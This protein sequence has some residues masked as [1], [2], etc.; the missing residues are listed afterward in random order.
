M[1][2]YNYTI[3]ALLYF[4]G[5]FCCPTY[6]ESTLN[7][8]TSLTSNIN[9]NLANK[10]EKIDYKNIV[11]LGK[12]W[13]FLKY[14]HPL[15]ASGKYDWDAELIKFLPV[16]LSDDSSN[17]KDEILFDWVVGFGS[18]CEKSFYRKKD[19]NLAGI[20]GLSTLKTSKPLTELLECIYSKNIDIK[21]YYVE[22]TPGIGNPS[23]KREKGYPEM[24]LPNERYRLLSLFRYWNI[25]HYFSPYKS[26]LKDN[27]DNV[28]N[29]HIE[30]FVLANNE[31][32]YQHAILGLISEIEDSHT[33]L[34]GNTKALQQWIGEYYP[35]IRVKFI[36]DKLVVVSFY[37]SVPNLSIKVGDVIKA[38][39]GIKISQLVDEMKPYYTDSNLVSTLKAIATDILR[40]DS[41]SIVIEYSHQ[42]EN[43][44]VSLPLIFKKDLDIAKWYLGDLTEPGYKILENG[45]GYVS[46]K[47]ITKI[48]VNKIK[49]ELVN[50][51]GLIIDLRYYPSTVV[52]YSLGQFFTNADNDFVKYKVFDV[53]NPGAFNLTKTFV[54]KKTIP[55]Y[56]GKI[57]LLV[58]EG[59]KSRGEFTTMA[60]QANANTIVVG[61]Q[62]AGASGNVSRLILPGGIKTMFTSIG[63][64]YP[65]GKAVQKVGVKLNFVVKPTIEGISKNQD[66]LFEFAQ[67]LILAK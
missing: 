30:N 24:A 2:I 18:P 52:A 35:P 10:I 48:D 14:Y 49:K 60:F 36:E 9:Y 45:I 64:Y 67:A 23:F 6:A 26:L 41:N 37:E 8:K 43:N 51:K 11:L 13:G 61:S 65:D 5:A 32:A 7:Y 4:L 44:T 31:L 40:S 63:V 1:K 12:V 66:E 46:L 25:I 59:T 39:N 16:F 34:S 33:Q 50:T 28:L 57:V 55:N 19:K 58:D 42:E 20:E 27:W 53:N 54:M 56:E 38:I 22:S 3:L 62:T 29:N 21:R 17:N 15:I 47:T